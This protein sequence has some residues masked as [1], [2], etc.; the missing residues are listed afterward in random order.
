MNRYSGEIPRRFHS[1]ISRAP[2][3][4]CLLCDKALLSGGEL[5]IIEKAYRDFGKKIGEK[6]LFEYAVCLSCAES[7]RKQLSVESRKKMDEFMS[8]IDFQKR[9]SL[10]EGEEDDVWLKNCLIRQIPAGESGEAQIY[11][12]CEGDRF[13]YGEFPYMI[14]AE[15]MDQIVSLLSS[16]TLDELDRFKESLTNG[17]SELQDL[18]DKVGP[19]FLV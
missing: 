3:D 18:F 16:E 8:N 6:T 9:A 10:L 19:R 15:A 5:Y 12:L 2:F 17:P 11:G 1:D 13:I 4:H 14:S 7:Y